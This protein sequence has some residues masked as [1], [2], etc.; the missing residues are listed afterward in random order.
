M[1]CARC[2]SP[3]ETPSGVDCPAVSQ[4]PAVSLPSD[5]EEQGPLRIGG[6]LITAALG[7]I[8]STVTIVASVMAS[9]MPLVSGARWVAMTTPGTATYR[10]LLAGMLLF[11][12]I[13]NG[14]LVAYILVTT[15]AFFQRRRIVPRLMM[16]FWAAQFAVPLLDTVLC[17]VLLE[18]GA[19][20]GSLYVPAIKALG[21]CAYFQRSER[22]KRTFVL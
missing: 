4:H 3:V 15:V 17:G 22:V 18:R 7:L 10:P 5:F 12:T 14:L 6:W 13:T 16:G 21:W 9:L 19:D 2:G 8:I 11:E 20:Y 1:H